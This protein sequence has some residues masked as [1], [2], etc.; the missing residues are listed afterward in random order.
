MADFIRFFGVS[1]QTQYV[2]NFTHQNLNNINNSYI[3]QLSLIL[4]RGHTTGI[5]IGDILSAKAEDIIEKLEQRALR[6]QQIVPS[7]ALIPLFACI[8]PATYILIFTPII[9]EIF[10]SQSL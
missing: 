7:K 6:F 5:T 3:E 1:K 2:V 4:K 8:F 10:Y 9:V